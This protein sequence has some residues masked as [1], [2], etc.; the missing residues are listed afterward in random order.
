[1]TTQTDRTETRSALLP[2]DPFEK[3]LAR[4]VG[5]PNGAHT[6][7]TIVQS[8]DFY[9]NVSSFMVQTVKWDEGTSVFLTEVR[10]GEQQPVRVV[11]PPKVLAAIARQQDACT[12]LVRK[13]HG[14]RLAETAKANGQLR[15]GGFTPAM[16][17]K[18]AATRQAKA[19]KRAAR[20]AARS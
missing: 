13:R 5:L 15:A 8:V 1:M 3:N 16:R 4:L 9:G 17:A 20:K 11:L 19:A 2:T 10:S 18:A 12:R 6:Q 7:P 14:Q